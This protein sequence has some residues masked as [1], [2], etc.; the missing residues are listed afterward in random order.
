[1]S[2]AEYPVALN[3]PDILPVHVVGSHPEIDEGYVEQASK[4]Y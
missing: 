2:F 3:I 1:M 4:Y